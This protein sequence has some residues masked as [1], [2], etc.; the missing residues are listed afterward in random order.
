MRLE[1]SYHNSAE[2]QKKLMEDHSA[3]IT[4]EKVVAYA[5]TVLKDFKPVGNWI[6]FG[7]VAF[8]YERKGDYH[9]H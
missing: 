7:G 1:S 8:W 3:K 9:E 4:T 2:E 6:T 5:I